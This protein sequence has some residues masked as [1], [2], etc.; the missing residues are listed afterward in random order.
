MV[1]HLANTPEW[2]CKCAFAYHLYLDAEHSASLRKR[3]SEMREPPLHLDRVPDPKLQH[4]L[5][6]VIRAETTL[7]LLVGIYEVVKPALIE[8]YQLHQLETNRFMDQPTYRA[9]RFILM[10]EEEMVAWGQSA[11]QALIRTKQDS[12]A[13][14]AWRSHLLSYLHHAGGIRGEHTQAE[15]HNLPPARFNGESYKPQFY[16][17]R[18]ERFIDMFNRSA[19]IDDYYQDEALQPDER[20]YALMCKRLREMDVPEWMCPILFTANDKPWDYYVDLS[21]QLYDEAR[22]A[23][24][25]EIVL[26]QSGI[27]FYRYPIDIKAS[28]SLNTAF[29]PLES[30]IILWG[31][32]QDLMSGKSGKKWEHDIAVQSG[33]PLAITLQDYDW[34]DEVLHAQIGRKWLQPEFGALSEMHVAYEEMRKKWIETTDKYVNLSEQTPW[35]PQFVMEMREGWERRNEVGHYGG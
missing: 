16:P 17:K 31:I 9:I 11:I 6:E 14:E 24:M 19:A 26:Y 8:A 25:G 5:E 12:E 35:W 3:V 7:E 32:E 27:P 29:T 30:H 10:E 18:D 28:V 33:M 20:T 22:H 13:A 34:A 4:V 2:E 23:M 15:P 21:R 1:A